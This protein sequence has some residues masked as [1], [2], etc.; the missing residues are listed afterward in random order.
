M[1]QHRESDDAPSADIQKLADLIEMIQ[2]A[3]LTT[4]GSDGRLYSRP[5]ATQ[6]EKFDGTLWFFTQR[7]SGKIYEIQQ[8][9]QINLSYS[10]PAKKPLCF[11]RGPRQRFA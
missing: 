3:M 1:S 2:I 8:D 9:Q 10:L 6:Q 7:L 11:R 4:I 5:M